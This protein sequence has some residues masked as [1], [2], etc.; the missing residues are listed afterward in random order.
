MTRWLQST[1]QGMLNAATADLAI[2]SLMRCSRSAATRATTGPNT[3]IGPDHLALTWYNIGA[4]LLV[5]T[6][7][8][9]PPGAYGMYLSAGPWGA[10]DG[11]RQ[12]CEWSRVAAR[13]RG[14]S[15]CLRLGLFR[16]WT[17]AL[18]VG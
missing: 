2:P 17:E 15:V 11:Q 1:M 13:A 12:A 10:A 8:H 4:P 6:Q 9:D 18:A 3:S 7:P 5:H 14:S 16:S